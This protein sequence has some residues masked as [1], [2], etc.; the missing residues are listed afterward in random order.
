MYVP[1]YSSRLDIHLNSCL[2]AEIPGTSVFR[3]PSSVPMKK[4]IGLLAKKRISMLQIEN[5]PYDVLIG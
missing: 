5:T 1:N 3:L 4:N 2:R